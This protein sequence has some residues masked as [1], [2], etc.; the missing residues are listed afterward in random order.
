MVEFADLMAKVVDVLLLAIVVISIFG[1]SFFL[2][3]MIVDEF[4][5][6]RKS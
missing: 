4:N 6:E 3:T 5:Q 1:T 2:T